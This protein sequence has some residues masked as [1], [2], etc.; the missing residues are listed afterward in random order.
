MYGNIDDSTAQ[1][2]IRDNVRYYSSLGPEAVSERIRQLDAEWDAARAVCAGLSG[3]GLFGLVVG[4]LGGRSFRLFT[5]LSLPLLFAASLGKWAP[6]AGL[7]A[8]WGFRSRR[9]IEE[10]RY[11][12]KALRGDFRDVGA[13]SEE[14]SENLGRAASRVLEAVRA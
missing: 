7:T 10:E 11:A 4:L 13:P 5:W 14:A 9:E 2:R 12:L 1:T 8:R 3:A 6:P